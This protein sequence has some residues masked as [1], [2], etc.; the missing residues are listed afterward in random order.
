M[1]SK[2]AILAL[3]VC[4]LIGAGPV[5]A[6]GS[7]GYTIA[8]NFAG[9]DY[10][11]SGFYPPDTDGAVG[12]GDVMEF[13]NGYVGVYSTTGSLLSSSSL[14]SFWSNA[15][16]TLGGGIYPG[17]VRVVY[18][19]SVN[20]WFA[21]SDTFSSPQTGNNQLLVAVSQN[22]SPLGTWSGFAINSSPSN[23]GLW[24]DY[25]TLG[26]NGQGVFIN[27]NM[28]TTGGNPTSN[29]IDVLSIPKASLLG[30]TPSISGYQ[31]LEG[32]DASVH[33]YAVQPINN[34]SANMP[35]TMY[36]NYAS[37]GGTDY[38]AQSQLSD[39]INSPTLS[40]TQSLATTTG[41]SSPVSSP[42]SGSTIL[43][44][45]VDN[46]FGGSLYQQPANS[47]S[48]GEVWEVI[49]VQNPSNSALDALQ[50]MRINPSTN[51]IDAS[52]L[53]SNPNLSFYDG[54][55]AVTPD[56][57]IVI[58]FSAS[59][60]STNP[61]AYAYIGS[62]DASTGGTNFTNLVPLIAGTSPITLGGDATTPARFGDYSTTVLDPTN[63]DA[64]WTFNEFGGGSGWNTQISEIA[65]TPVPEPAT[66]ALLALGGL[67]LLA[68][69]K[70]RCEP[71]G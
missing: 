1:N 58:G 37:S 22:S 50:W 42:Q 17:D 8:E 36:A 35:E 23:S 32:V 48:I 18:D 25:P 34:F 30:A 69:R 63:P 52:G 56:G 7:A 20:R 62:Y 44:D 54:S 60:S 19:S 14:S 24:A 41:Y 68:R 2:R 70:K 65:F 26:V 27:A 47:T 71:P 13:I 3:T 46:R 6:Y 55:I 66:L 9:G 49:T 29:S 39:S 28:F 10:S 61:S 21:S 67:A 64:V 51:T 15:G 43:V 12:G 53:L 59:S 57:H 40:N 33:G 45:A 16:V 4:A 38:I 5:A 31:L 11:S